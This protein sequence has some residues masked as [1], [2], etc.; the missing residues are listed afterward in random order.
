MSASLVGSEMCIRDRLQ[1]A[2]PLNAR[3][4][5]SPASPFVPRSA[6]WGWPNDP[7]GRRPVGQSDATPVG[8]LG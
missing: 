3:N 8:P 4:H 2:T 7:L 6:P 1:R 5:R